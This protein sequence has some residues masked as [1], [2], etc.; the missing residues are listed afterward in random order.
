MRNRT[1]CVIGVS[2]FQALWHG[3]ARGG[4]TVWPTPGGGGQLFTRR[5]GLLWFVVVVHR[6]GGCFVALVVGA[7]VVC[8][9]DSVCLFLCLFLFLSVFGLGRWPLWLVGF[10]GL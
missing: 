3:G 1:E 8:E 4:V 9:P 10:S 2:P 7:G 5:R 6:F